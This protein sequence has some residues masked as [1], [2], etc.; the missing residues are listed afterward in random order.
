MRLRYLRYFITV[1]EE[2]SFKR[3]STRLHIEPSPMSRAIGK[4]ENDVGVELLQRKKGRIRLTEAGDAF[5]KEA[6]RILSL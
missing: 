6:R 1:P 3:A 2:L 5:R 4:L